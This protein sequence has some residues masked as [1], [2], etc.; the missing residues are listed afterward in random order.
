[1]A[2]H[3]GGCYAVSITYLNRGQGATSTERTSQP[4]RL[5][6]KTAWQGVDHRVLFGDLASKI[7][8]VK[9]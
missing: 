8:Q 6:D 4:A 2:E 3:G 9:N 1:M 7:H 5:Y